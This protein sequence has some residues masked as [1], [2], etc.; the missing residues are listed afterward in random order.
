MVAN[1]D[2]DDDDLFG[3]LASRSQVIGSSVVD[4]EF[5]AEIQEAR[6]IRSHM[7][8]FVGTPYYLAP[9]MIANSSAGI[10][11]DLWALGVIAY[12]LLV[13]GKPFDAKGEY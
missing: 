6:N 12:E 1:Y 13:G 2:E 11:N 5:M 8:T 10:F 4:M 7:G 9:E 3:N